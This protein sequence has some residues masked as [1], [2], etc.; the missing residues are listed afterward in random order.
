MSRDGLRRARRIVVKV[1]T[2]LLAPRDG[3]VHVRR[4]AELA[5]EI[6]G[7]VANGLQVVLVSSGAVGLGV[8]RLGL[9]ERPASIPAKQAAAAV[10]Q[11]DLCRRFERAFARH[12][13]LVG[14]ILLTHQGLAD[15]ERF[16]NA[17]QTLHALLA[18]GVVPLINENDSVATEELRVGDNDLLSAMVVNLSG[19]DLLVMLTDTDGL[20]DGHPN[21]P[22]SRRIAEVPQVTRALLEVADSRPADPAAQPGAAV[23]T[24][25]MRAK[26]E[27]ARLASRYGVPTVIVDGAHRGAIG[28]ILHGED[29]GTHVHASSRQLSSRKHW[30]ASLKPRGS[31]HLD[32]GAV[33]AITERGRSLLPIGI[34]EVEG[35]F[36]RGDP[37]RCVAGDGEEIA[38]ALSAYDARE[39]ELIKGQRT[40]RIEPLL[41]Y[42]NGDAVAHRDDL[43]LL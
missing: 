7:L 38:R 9:T 36:G 17:R 35:Q 3:G 37:V 23:G 32:E 16:L 29:T 1:G 40:P 19:A 41:G 4:F 28:R 11:I 25:G 27:A 8:R 14:Q 26:L 20:F 15:R 6:A 2:S 34:V 10:G 22:G 18:S 30:I 39:V 13:L 24:G 21:D 5:D 31:L 12:D 33:R 42:T 43:V